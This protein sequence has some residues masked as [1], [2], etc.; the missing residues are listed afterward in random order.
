MHGSGG[1]TVRSS[2]AIVAALLTTTAIAGAD[3]PAFADVMRRAHGY[4]V[5]Y[6]DTELSSVIAH[7]R[8]KQERLDSKAKRKGERTLQ[9]DYLLFQVPPDE[10]W[11]ALRDVYEVDG[12]AVAQRGERLKELFKGDTTLP[13]SSVMEIVNDSARFNMASELYYRTV[14]VPTFALRFLRP[15]SRERV[16]FSK[17][18]EEQIAGTK[19]W[20]I[21]YRETR[22]PT[23]SATPEGRDLP[24]QGRFWIEP[25]SGAVIRSEMI[26]GGSR[27]LAAR[28]NI[29]V[30]YGV[31]PTLAF[32]VPVEMRERYDNPRREKDDVVVTEAT[33]SNFRPFDRRKL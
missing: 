32:R 26:L 30:T 24:A 20:V 14:N 29:T 12:Q 11:L 28:V 10:D 27:R 33:Y 3:D 18:G 7:E 5:V 22:G 8:Y 4:V 17:A 19:T 9:S 21:A 6:E 25:E 16:T 1:V 2:L 23:F 31:E 13:A 15:S